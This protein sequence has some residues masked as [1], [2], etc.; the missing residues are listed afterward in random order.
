[1]NN[2]KIPV[3]GKGNNVREWIHVRDHNKC[4]LEIAD[5]GESGQ[6]YNIG[7]GVELSNLQLIQKILDE[8][9]GRGTVALSDVI[10]YVEDRKGHDLRYA[11]E[12][13][14]FKYQ[15]KFVEFE[16][17]LADTINFYKKKY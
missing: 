12:S 2:E 5:R 13:K 3:Y 8:L 6:V 14:Y 16:A 15:T 11:I 7:S 17:G 4:V 9:H 1:M 10:E